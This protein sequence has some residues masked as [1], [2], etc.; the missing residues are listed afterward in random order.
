MANDQPR[1]CSAPRISISILHKHPFLCSP[2][3][4]YGVVMM[5]LS[6]VCKGAFKLTGNSG[7]SLET[8][9]PLTRRRHGGRRPGHSSR[10]WLASGLEAFYEPAGLSKRL[11]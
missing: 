5:R 8:I 9:T 2:Q 7:H 10:W 3:C 4:F 11:A 6:L 1:W